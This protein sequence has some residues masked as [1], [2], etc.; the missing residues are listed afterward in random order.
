MINVFQPTLGSREL[1]AVSDVFESAWLG[2]GP[3]TTDFEA[4]F[5]HHLGV[6]AAHVRTIPSCTDGLFL[7]MELL[8]IEAGDEVI[9]PSISFVGA[10]NAIAAAGA[11]PVFCD[12]DPRSLNP[13]VTDIE[14]VVSPRTRAI[15]PLHY[16]GHPGD[17]VDIAA[18]AA[19][20]DLFLIEDAACSVASAVDGEACGV[21]G[22]IGVW[23]FDAMKILV[24]GDGGMIYVKD[25]ERAAQLAPLTYLGMKES[26]GFSSAANSK[27]WWEFEVSSFSRRSITNDIA[28]AIGM[29]QLDRLEEFVARRR[30]IHEAYESGLADLPWLELP[31]A[32]PTGVTSSFYMFWVQLPSAVQRDALANY[33]LERDIYTTFR[34]YPLHLV[35]AYGHEGPLPGAESA[36][37]RTLCLPL[38]Q[39]LDDRD[40]AQV[41][42]SVRNFDPAVT[43]AA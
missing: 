18:F 32:T 24:T 40:V 17:I 1:D 25:P 38:H 6:P 37:G 22:D 12:V 3:R 28:A 34:Y 39:G 10:A 29:V 14:A 4:R 35:E 33:L 5:A 41:V 23:S 27:R 19:D 2:R 8:G 26:S 42:E 20:R 16:G 9:L 7:S 36:A 21:I 13:R 11:T 31:P 43:K 30:E 15:L